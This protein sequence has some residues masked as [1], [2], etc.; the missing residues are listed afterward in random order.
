M[1]LLSRLADRL[2][3][4]ARSRLQASTH[5]AAWERDNQESLAAGRAGNSTAL[6]VVLGVSAAQGTRT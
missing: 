3:A 6:W 1:A 5:P 4:V 2:P